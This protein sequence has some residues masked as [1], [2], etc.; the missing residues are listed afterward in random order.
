MKMTE[1]LLKEAENLVEENVEEEVEYEFL[2]EIVLVN[3]AGAERTVTAPK[4]VPGRVYRKAISLQ[5]KTRKLMYKNDGKGKY[6]RDEEGYLVPSESTEESD[7]Q[8]LDLYE[9]FIVE[10]FNNQFTVDELREG[11]DARHYQET[12]THAYQSALGNP[13]VE[14]KVKQK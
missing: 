2:K 12:L 9:E 1:E 10:Y 7:L 3:S 14:V 5:Y 8:A 13:T 4:V 6:E 11:L